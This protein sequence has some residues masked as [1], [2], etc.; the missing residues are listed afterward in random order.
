[1]FSLLRVPNEK[2]RD[3]LISDVKQRV[4]SAKHILGREVHFGE[5]RNAIMKGFEK[6][7]DAK[8]VPG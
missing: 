7:F 2:I 8:L 5:A 3:K 4:T 1:M 6:A